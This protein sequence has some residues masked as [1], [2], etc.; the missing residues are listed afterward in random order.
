MQTAR[1]QKVRK[2]NFRIQVAK[3][4]QALTAKVAK[5]GLKPQAMYGCGLRGMPPTKVGQLRRYMGSA[6]PGRHW[7]KSVTLRLAIAGMDPMH[8]IRADPLLMWAEG[9][10][11]EEL[12]GGKTF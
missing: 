6:L 11:D 1:L 7:R 12:D 5:H 4:Y 10:W 8:S 3:R 2:R 9:V